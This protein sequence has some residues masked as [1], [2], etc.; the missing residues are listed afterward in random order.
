M[1]FENSIK[2]REEIR[3][4]KNNGFVCTGK[5]GNAE[6][7][8]KNADHRIVMNDGTVRRGIPEFRKNNAKNRIK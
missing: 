4:L 5:A 7:Y 3:K 2:M 1:T 6:Y 8:S